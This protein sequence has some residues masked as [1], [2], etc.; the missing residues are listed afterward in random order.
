M[1]PLLFTDSIIRDIN[2]IQPVYIGVRNLERIA[3]FE[4]AF[5][6]DIV[7]IAGSKEVLTGNLNV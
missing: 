4:C 7:I 2:R 6:N 5:T 1:R 3:V